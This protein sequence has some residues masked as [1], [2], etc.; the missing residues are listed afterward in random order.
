[1]IISRE[2]GRYPFGGVLDADQPRALNNL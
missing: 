1:L 2:Q